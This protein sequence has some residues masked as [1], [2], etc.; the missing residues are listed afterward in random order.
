MHNRIII[1][2]AAILCFG[3]PLSAQQLISD[4]NVQR[5]VRIGSASTGSITPDQI[6]ASVNDYNPTGLATALLLRLSS[7]ASRTITGIAAGTT[8]AGRSLVL[9]NVGAQPIILANESSSSAAANRFAIGGSYTIPAG[10]GV[11]V[12]YDGTAS[13]WRLVSTT[14]EGLA[15]DFQ[16]LSSNLT[17]FAG[18][19]PSANT[20]SF[21]G[22]ADYSAMRTQ[23]SLVPGTDV[24]GVPGSSAEGDLLYRNATVWTRLPRGTT[25]QV[26][27]STATTIAWTAASS[28]MTNP[29]TTAGDVIKGGASGTP[30]R[31]AIGTNGQ[32]LK[33]VGG[34]LAWDTDSGGM[35]NPM[36]TLGDIIR[37]AASGTPE[38]LGI[39]TEGQVLKVSS[40][41]A[42][43]GTDSGA[44]S[45]TLA[46]FTPLDNQPPAATFSTFD[47]RNSIA[48]LDYDADTNESAV[49]VGTIPDGADFTTGLSVR[50]MWMASTATSGNVVW[51]TAFERCNGSNLNSD[52]F[53]AGIDSAPAPANGTSGI[54]TVTTINHSGAQIGGLVAGD[55]FRVKLTRNATSGSDTMTGDAELIAIEIRQQ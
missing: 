53:A 25:G 48:L 22:A 33:V 44:G 35:T 43:W 3:V 20:Q 31:L 46:R 28:G 36:T 49:F 45:L 41:V 24:I 26:L 50:I 37:G 14:K 17:I 5:S 4:L 51:T 52:N 7:D 27:A 16:P 30:E 38:R 40:G 9:S 32:V 11:S 55:L 6:T 10:A 21:L 54:I 2:L 23:L 47:T 18:I 15:G 34:A 39:G 29:M 12:L 8:P 1:T 19:T 13:R 42:A